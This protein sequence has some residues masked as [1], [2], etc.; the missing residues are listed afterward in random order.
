MPA[1]MG[2]GQL[3]LP[4]LLRQAAARRQRAVAGA[5]R[6]QSRPHADTSAC[7]AAHR[8]GPK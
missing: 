1:V 8:E 4:P 3:A 6:A 2:T 5:E 7:E